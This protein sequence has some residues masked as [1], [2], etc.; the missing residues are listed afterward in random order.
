MV[1]S[2]YTSK[3]CCAASYFFEFIVREFRRNSCLLPDQV[4]CRDFKASALGN[5]DGAYD[6]SNSLHFLQQVA[7]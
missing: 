1:K 4:A 6:I 7:V 5:G 3:G 2:F